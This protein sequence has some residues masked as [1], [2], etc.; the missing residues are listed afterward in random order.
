MAHLSGSGSLP[1][2][3][4][5]DA[6]KPTDLRFSPRLEAL[7]GCAA[8]SVAAFHCWQTKWTDESG[9]TVTFLSSCGG[10]GSAE[11]LC[12]L[13]LNIAGNGLGAVILFFVLSGFVLSGSLHR[14]QSDATRFVTA[15]LFRIYPAVF[16]S[17]AI[18][19]AF[20][21]AT[22]LASPQPYDIVT[23]VR[24]ALLL[25]V[26]IDG[27][28]WSLQLEMIAIPIL[29]IGFRLWRR[30]GVAPLVVLYI[31]LVALSFVGGWQ[32]LIGEPGEF[33]M[34]QAFIPG[35]LAYVL[36][37]RVVARWTP[38]TAT[39]AFTIVA[40]SFLASRPLIHGVWW[41]PIAEAAFGAI[42]VA[43][44]AFS[45]PGGIAKVFDLRLFLFFGRISFSFYLLHP[46]T[47]LVM[48]N[49]PGLRAPLAAAGLPPVVIA[50]VLFVSSVAVVTPL[51][52][53]MYH[54]IERPGIEAYRRLVRGLWGAQT[55]SLRSPVE[56]HPG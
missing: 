53:A 33:G 54:W 25:D 34:I 14:G 45:S 39:V 56:R 23:M 10:K 38:R 11:S 55:M 24:N 3:A 44:L 40:A 27:V 15:R 1:R 26:S 4:D 20:N 30:W 36:A 47:L 7:R 42:G 8:L 2:A 43:I 22:R 31:T 12:T 19:A 13:S 9:Q 52:L 18:F 29:L 37:P 35:M 17:V 50:V 51:A 16:A 49:M 48:W 32:R 21:W 5:K 46:L 41:S 28:M 6:F